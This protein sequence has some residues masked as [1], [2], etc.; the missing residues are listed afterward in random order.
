MG[1]LTQLQRLRLDGSRLS[2]ALPAQLTLLSGVT[3][4]NF[5]LDGN[6]DLCVNSAASAAVV[7]LCNQGSV[8][9]CPMSPCGCRHTVCAGGSEHIEV[10]FTANKVLTTSP[11]YIEEA[12]CCQMGATTL[13]ERVDC[14]LLHFLCFACLI[15]VWC[16]CLSR[17]FPRHN[18]PFLTCLEHFSCQLVRDGLLDCSRRPCV[19]TPAG[20]ARTRSLEYH[21]NKLTGSI[22]PQIG[23][24]PVLG[25]LSLYDNPELQGTIPSQVRC[26]RLYAF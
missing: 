25:G 5:R 17:L 22:P 20:L 24:L 23:L 26:Q 16:G 6:P 7:P 8:G 1:L 18:L 13:R 11:F 4:V 3:T 9:G 14:V 21:E 2:G 19:A 12:E 15:D 10:A